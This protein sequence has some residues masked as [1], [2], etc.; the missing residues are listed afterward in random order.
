MFG[1]HDGAGSGCGSDVYVIQVD[2][3]I[4]CVPVRSGFSE[5]VLSLP[6]GSRSNERAAVDGRVALD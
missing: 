1:F 4:A 5:L 3:L 6:S 2:V